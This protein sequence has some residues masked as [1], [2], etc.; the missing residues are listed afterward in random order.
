MTRRIISL[1]IAVS[2]LLCSCTSPSI[3]PLEIDEKNNNTYITLQPMEELNKFYPND[4]L[5]FQL[6]YNT[7]NQIRFPNNYNI[8]LF[9]LDNSMWVEINEIPTR[10]HPLGDVVFSQNTYIPFPYVISLIPDLPD[11]TK[12]Y[13]LFVYVSG[14]MSSNASKQEVYASTTVLI[15]PKK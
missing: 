7:I 14:L 1:F 12:K 8:R 9:Y 5:Y 4:V 3:E 15:S 2:V 11:K 10:R 6:S 13:Q